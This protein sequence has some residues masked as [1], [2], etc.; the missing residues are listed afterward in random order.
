MNSD[1]GIGTGGAGRVFGEVG[2]PLREGRLQQPVQ[3]TQQ[4]EWTHATTAPPE[5]TFVPLRRSDGAAALLTAVDLFNAAAV[6][7]PDSGSHYAA[8]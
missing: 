2:R 4:R 1:A 6:R 8:F 3:R 7:E 5:E